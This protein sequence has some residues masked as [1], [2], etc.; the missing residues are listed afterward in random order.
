MTIAI[1][2]LG[3]IGGSIAKA[4]KMNTGHRVLGYDLQESVVLRAKLL[5]AIDEALSPPELP[6]CDLVIV[7]LYPGDT[8]TYVTENAGRFKKGGMVVDCAGVKHSVCEALWP[9]ARASSFSFIGGHPMAGVERWGFENA[10]VGLFNRA[11]M[12][13]V[14]DP[15]AA[16]EVPEAIKKLFL[17][18][19]FGSITFAGP[20][21]HDRIIAYTSQLAHVLSSAYIKSETAQRHS[22]FSAGSFRDMT[23]VATMNEAMWSELFLEN[24][25]PL[26]AEIDGLIQRLAEYRDA[27][28]GGER[29]TL[30]ALLREGTRRKALVSNGEGPK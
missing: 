16:L 30:M 1:V 25:E 4:I 27:I 17:S 20:E 18:M 19:G 22:G 14:P 24:R 5:G 15:E 2:G 11:S 21:A 28:S 8:V 6:D 26:V 3:L 7:A 29:E 13:L 12:I 9:V 10:A 23:R